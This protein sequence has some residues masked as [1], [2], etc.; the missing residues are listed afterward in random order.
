ML[1]VVYRPKDVTD[2]NMIIRLVYNAKIEK[3]LREVRMTGRGMK[4]EWVNGAKF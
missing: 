4:S 3:G 1:D 2:S